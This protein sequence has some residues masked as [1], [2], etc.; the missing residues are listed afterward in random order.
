MLLGQM[1]G[2]GYDW[3]TQSRHLVFNMSALKPNGTT[4]TVRYEVNTGSL[5]NLNE[6]ARAERRNDKFVPD[7]RHS[8]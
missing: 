5:A 4:T 3:S 7:L 2:R 1:Q 6:L 8:F